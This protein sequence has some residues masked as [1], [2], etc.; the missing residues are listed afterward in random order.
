MSQT[1]IK[2]RVIP[3]KITEN[4][5]SRQRL[6][7]KFEENAAKNMILVL[8][9]AGY[10]KTTSVLDFLAESG[11][12]YAWLYI[13]Q[14]IDSAASFLSY[15][16]HSLKVL[17]PGFGDE[18]LELI[19]SFV[20]SD[21]FN[22]DESNTIHATVASLINEFVEH[23]Q[24]DAF[25]VADDLHNIEEASWLG[26]IFDSLTENFPDNLH[27]IITS[28]NA[29]VFNISRLK[30]KRKL[31]VIE[32]GDLNFTADETERL[33]KEIYSLKYK[34]ED[35]NLLIDKFEGW[36]T[37]LHLILQTYGIEF[38]KITAEKQELGGDLFNYF[39]EDIFAQLD[40]KTRDFLLS[41]S[42]LDS[43]TQELCASVLKLEGS[44]TI[45]GELKRKNLFIES[46]EHVDDKGKTETSYSYHSLFRQFLYAKLMEVKSPAEIKELSEKV[47]DHYLLK[48]DKLQ[49][50]EFSL[51]SEH[52][53][54]ASAL[55]LENSDL[56]F[57]SAG[58]ETLRRWLSLIPGAE[59]SSNPKL[60]FINGKLLNFFKTDTEGAYGIFKELIE[61][62]KA[63][64]ALFV[65]ANLEI[66]EI[67][68]LTGRPD[69]ALAILKELYSKKTE[70]ELRI[71]IIIS[72]AKCYYRLGSK[73]Y[74]NILKLAAEGESL[75]N[76]N[77]SE[78]LLF[79]IYS[80]Y[81]RIY[82]NKGE[83]VKSLHYFESSYRRESNLFRKFQTVSD[84]I[85]LQSWSGNYERAKE[86]Y[87]EAESL[88]KKIRI[89]FLERDLI[90]LNAL[91]RAEAG[92]FEG[93]IEGITRLS[94]ID[95]KNKFTSFLPAYNLILS[96]CSMLLGE[97]S[98][99]SEYIEL[100]VKFKD[101]KDEYLETELEYH[102]ALLEKATSPTAKTE[103]VLLNTLKHYEQFS[104]LYNKTQV[105]LHLADLY[106]KKGEQLVSQQYL[107]EC[108]ASAREKKYHSFLLQ[109]FRPMRYLFDSAIAA[110]IEK[111]FVEHLKNSV[112]KR[113]SISWLTEECR[114]RLKKENASLVDISLKAFGG[115]E[116]SV[117][118]LAIPEEAWLR[119][120]SKLLLVYLLIN[121]GIRIQ[122]DKVLGIFFAELSPESADNIF[123]Q[124]ITNIRNVLKPAVAGKTADESKAKRSKKTANA[125]SG[126]SYI[127][128]EDKILHMATGFDFYVDVLEFNRLAALVKSPET[129][130][131]LKIE[132]A[133]EAI[134]IYR[135]EF[136]P[137]YYDE[138][139]EEL[140]SILE[141]KYIEICE[142]LLVILE[143]NRKFDELIEFSEKLLQK[144]K[145]HEEAYFSIINAYSSIGNIT[146]AKKKLSQLI[147]TYDEEYGEKPPKALMSKIMNIGGLQ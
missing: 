55:I 81:G 48:G 88:H 11:R 23:F 119:K 144:D 56:L 131:I 141:H 92:D 122:K 100:A 90:R 105:Q 130:S 147:K 28:R 66:A 52:Y 29:P 139:I 32:S 71:R 22:R 136:L 85:L 31:A 72:L 108:F 70:P 83:F 65:K 30:A 110:G 10:G 43:F 145:L 111:D 1:I 146:M 24:D 20:Q 112:V 89:G 6:L 115:A 138:W 47:F 54:S 58:Y 16:I 27:L 118:G 135:G 80:L 2:T 78:H 107:C 84:I 40:E 103:K 19:N 51:R 36:I 69:E 62:S 132:F 113:N 34:K 102:K 123:H 49:A 42:M 120:K 104:S 39:A 101:P 143:K 25:L 38:N 37:G 60:R 82:L 53:E 128:Y 26:S 4:I 9:P 7:K 99:S 67:Q 97:Y 91:L 126:V 79:D 114:S 124:A 98:K 133:K 12:K 129:D 15:F 61:S 77:N 116:I 46:A 63:D 57:Q 17:K 45:P 137:G 3:K 125:D 73:Y 50:I 41:T 13:S 76:E 121:Q 68:R 8:G 21:L 75:A 18:T 106:Y 109:H 87:D 14:D 44:S 5:V 59:I 140:R 64:S 134:A 95:V 94:S 74:D 35:V 117:R 86:Y 33:L 96:E 142:E 93:A 127:V